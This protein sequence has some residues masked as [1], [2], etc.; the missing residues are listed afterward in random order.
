MGH[1]D[2]LHC[3]HEV[4]CTTKEGSWCRHLEKHIDGTCYC[5]KKG[6]SCQMV[7]IVE[8]LAELYLR[9]G[10]VRRVPVPSEL[11]VLADPQHSIELQRV[12]LKAHHGGLWF[13]GDEWLI[14]YNSR[15]S[16]GAIRYTI[17][18]EAYHILCR[19][20]GPAFRG[21]GQ[22]QRPFDEVVADYFAACILMPRKWVRD[23]WPSMH[24]IPRMA[25]IFRVS[26]SAMRMRLTQL[27]FLDRAS[28]SSSPSFEPEERAGNGGR[29]CSA[30]RRSEWGGRLPTRGGESTCDYYSGDCPVERVCHSEA[31]EAMS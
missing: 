18:H 7:R 31:P 19:R 10:D 27:G 13:T 6:S 3:P 21:I 12:P 4:D 23:K 17:F 16:L 11:V 5:L 2:G 8:A 26:E 14:Q 20:I 29:L 28:D 30:Q 15:E 22:G 24:S 1:G 9:R 25:L